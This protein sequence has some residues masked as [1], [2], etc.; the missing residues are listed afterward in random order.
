MPVQGL[1]DWDFWLS[2]SEHGWQFAYLTEALFDYRIAQESMITRTHGFE[3]QVAEFIAKKHGLLHR[4]AWLQLS[5]QQESLE[6][7][8]RNF[9]SVLRAWIRAQIDSIPYILRVRLWY[10]ILN[11]TRPVRHALGLRQRSVKPPLKNCP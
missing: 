9:H 5:N 10:P 7:A 6:W 8:F 3:E 2:A 4:Q 11:A 1:E